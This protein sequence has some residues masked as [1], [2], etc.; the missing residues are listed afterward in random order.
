MILEIVSHWIQ[1]YRYSYMQLS[2]TCSAALV[3][4]SHKAVASEKPWI[5]RFYYVVP[6]SL[7]FVCLF[8]ETWIFSNYML[9]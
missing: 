3:G 7:F 1:M 5:L 2:F 6:Y 9:Y 8:N 4:K